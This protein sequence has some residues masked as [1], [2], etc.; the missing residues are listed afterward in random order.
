MDIRVDIVI[1]VYVYICF[2]DVFYKVD[3]WIT[4]Y[5]TTYNL[6]LGKSS[7]LVHL[8]QSHKNP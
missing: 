8:L 7:G 2:I 6:S 1:C 5:L 3:E 4:N